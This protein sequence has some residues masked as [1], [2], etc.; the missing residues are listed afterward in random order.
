[1]G[2]VD[3]KTSILSDVTL[4]NDITP[5]PDFILNNEPFPV[6]D[7]VNSVH[8]RASHNENIENYSVNNISKDG[9]EEDC[10]T[11]S[12]PIEFGLSDALASM[13]SSS[14]QSSSIQSSLPS[15]RGSS[16]RTLSSSSTT[17]K[18]IP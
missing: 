12:E 6:A 11:N 7:F 13:Q 16:D 15:T 2:I 9:L 17:L 5:I 18:R 1:M 3:H 10:L 8:K 4:E 14:M